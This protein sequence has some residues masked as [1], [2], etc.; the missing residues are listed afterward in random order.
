MH[1]MLVS[2]GACLVLI[3]LIWTIL[4]AISQFH[5]AALEAVNIPYRKLPW[6]YNVQGKIKIHFA[7]LEAVNIPY[8]NVP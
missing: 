2:G 4:Q 5:F 3:V 8:R 7:A 1:K 6:F